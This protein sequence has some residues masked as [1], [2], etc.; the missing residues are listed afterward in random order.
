MGLRT[1]LEYRVNFLFALLSAVCPAV[2]Q[3]ALWTSLYGADPGELL[4]GFTYNQMI[5]YV[6]IANLVSRTVRTGFEY[7]LAQDIKSG[8]LDR[9]LVKPIGYFGFRLFAFL[10]AKSAQTVVMVAV[11]TAAVLVMSSVL[12]FPIAAAA[13]LGFCAAILIAFALNFLIFWCVGT[14]AFRLTEIGFLFEAVRIVI[15]TASGGIFPLSVFGPTGEAI[16]KALPFR[17]TIQFPTE[18][19]CGR[20][21]A[22]EVLADFG[23][24]A[25]WI[26]VLVILAR[27]LWANGVRRFAAVGS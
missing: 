9:F 21:P 25:A 18:L 14:L 13:I 12:A 17:F 20:I 26:V 5:A 11:L 3:T 23:M 15:I 6:V 8:G 10:G 22:G 19:L 7:E 2:I 27:L 1:A 16:L 24:A 4:F